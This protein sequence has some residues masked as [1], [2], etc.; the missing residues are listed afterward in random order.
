MKGGNGELLEKCRKKKNIEEDGELRNVFQMPAVGDGN[1]E[2]AKVG[3]WAGW[4]RWDF[5]FMLITSKDSL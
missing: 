3:V 5:D 1:A 4:E 2:K